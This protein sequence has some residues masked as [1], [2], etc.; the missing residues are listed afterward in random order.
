MVGLSG[1][2]AFG[3]GSGSG[4]PRRAWPEM[5]EHSL[6]DVREAAALLG[7]SPG[8][9]YHW[10]REEGRVPFVR[11]G[12]RCVRFRR[13]DLEEWISQKSVRTAETQIA[14]RGST[15]TR[16]GNSTGKRT[17]INGVS[18]NENRALHID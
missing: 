12:P 2:G 9:L 18:R 13:S 14:A 4:K 8:T 15:F 16:E 10:L 6:L 11:L 7:I 5:S 3:L 1:Q 17:P